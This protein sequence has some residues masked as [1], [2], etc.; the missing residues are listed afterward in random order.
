MDLRC[1]ESRRVKIRVYRKTDKILEVLGT[2]VYLECYALEMAMDCGLLERSGLYVGVECIECWNSKFV[3]VMDQD[4]LKTV[5][6]LDYL[7]FFMKR[8]VGYFKSCWYAC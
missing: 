5:M 1:S 4:S 2:L 7:W 6:G 3:S 8:T